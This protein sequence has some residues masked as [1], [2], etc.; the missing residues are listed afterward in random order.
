MKS[1]KAQKQSKTF[2]ETNARRKTQRCFVRKL[3]IQESKLNEVQ[4]EHLFMLFVEAKRIQN[5][6]L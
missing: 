4:R 5:E 2:A 6:A 1:E 3:K